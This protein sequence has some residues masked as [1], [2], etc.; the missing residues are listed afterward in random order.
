M[1]PRQPMPPRLA[2]AL[3]SCVPLGD[4]RV[5]VEADLR[6]L[7]HARASQVGVRVARR[8]FWG[9]VFSL[10]RAEARGRTQ[11]AHDA[12]SS[13]RFAGLSGDIAFAIRIFR[14]QMGVTSVAIGGLAVA[15]GVCTAVFTLISATTLR[16]AGVAD[17]NALVE[18]NHTI[19][20]SRIE[21][22]GWTY[23]DFLQLRDASKLVKVEASVGWSAPLAFAA[24]AAD[25]PGV[26]IRFV[27]GSFVETF[28]GRVARGRAPGPSDDIPGAPA[29]A[30]IH[31]AFWRVRLGADPAIVGRTIYLGG[32]PVTIVGIFDGAYTGPFDSRQ[33]PAMVLPMSA[34]AAIAPHAGPFTP[35]SS[36]PVDGIGRLN[37]PAT[38][39]QAQS[40]IEAI[41]TAR[42]WVTTSGT[43]SSI[44]GLRV[45][46]GGSP[47]TV[48]YLGVFAAIATLVGL[49]LLL[50]AANVANLL[51]A[52]ATTRGREIGTRLAL[53][54]SRSRIVRQ[55]LTESV[56][57]G[58]AAGI[59][60]GLMTLWITPAVGVMLGVE[61]TIDL[62]PD[63]GVWAF[64]AVISALAGIVTG[65]APAR[66]GARGD[67][68]ATLKGGSN[69]A[70][71]T[72]RAGRL[73]SIFQGAQAAAALLL[74]VLTAL[75]GRALIAT[76]RVPIGFD[77][78]AIAAVSAFAPRSGSRVPTTEFWD[79]AL[80]RVRAM[81]GVERA[82][83]VEYPP[84]W[85][86]FH[87]VPTTRQGQR[88]QVIENRTT[89]EYFE[90]IGYRVVQGRTYTADEVAGRARVMVISDTLARDFYP[91][92]DA[93]GASYARVDARYLS[94]FQIIGVVVEAAPKIWSPNY[95]GAATIYRPI[96]D[97]ETAR[98]VY[99]VRAAT[100]SPA[101]AVQ[102]SLNAVDPLRLPKVW[103]VREGID[104]EFR[105]PRLFASVAGLLGAFA[106]VLAVI[107]VFGV[108]AFVVGQRRREIGIRLALG[109]GPSAVVRT[110]F[111]QGVRPIAIGLVVG[112]GL[113]LLASPIVGKLLAAG[114]SARDPLSFAA[115]IAVLGAA[116]GAGVWIPARRAARVDPVN[117]LKAQ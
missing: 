18:I 117:V 21:L 4:R 115:A 77:P 75:A 108:T 44:L 95:S 47:E 28:G 110:I 87:P 56:M 103:S 66:Y 24:G 52:G 78:D 98:M 39:V 20:V 116:A 37:R 104:E 83:L 100:A 99:R 46:P 36:A 33:L 63:P 17:P 43:S 90:T 68:V 105:G 32:V 71:D 15:I 76:S 35:T 45:K 30:A 102:Q 14:R 72:P 107:G 91:D 113:A 57:L 93:V 31:D 96:S 70:G 97:L 67:V 85:P 26:R 81:P 3:L 13:R 61:P 49:V 5:E 55:L 64:V 111:G 54:A 51:L 109:A 88:Y 10:L 80:E 29:V 38:I 106:L 22:D 19:G 60:G 65:L 59:A 50:A 114:V 48:R 25:G 101:S 73:R 9:D 69:Q 34:A 40:E 82:A 7:F 58:L 16:S 6:E 86:G 27:T 112:L 42:G 11:P 53:G 79:I 62:A 94:D 84:F 2:R 8:R 74:L 1:S 92:G 12:T 89:A 41:G 23:A